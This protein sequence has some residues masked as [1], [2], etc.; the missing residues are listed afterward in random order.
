MSDYYDLLGIDPGADKDTIKS[1]Y[2]ERLEDAS[3]SERAKLNKAWN[4]LSDPVQRER[5]D[6]ARAEGWLDDAEEEIEVVDAAPRG[7]RGSRGGGGGGRE[8]QPRPPARPRPE[9]T[10]ELPEGMVLAENRE[11][12]NALLIDFLILFVVFTLGQFGIQA[13]VKAQYPAQSDRIDAIQKQVDKL[14]KQK[15]AQDKVA[16]GEKTKLTENQTPTKAQKAA[17]KTES[18][19]LDKRI[20]KLQDQQTEISKDYL[21]FTYL[22]LGG[23]V[24]VLLAIVVPITAITG[25]TIGQKIKK[26]RIVRQDGSPCGWGPAILRFAPP[27]LIAIVIPTLGALIGLGMV[28]WFLR[29]PNRQGFH[30]KLAKTIVVAAD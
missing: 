17:A 3:Q 26:V 29:D 12:G 5:Y 15:S 24:I 20:T 27:I 22:L 11:R 28:L 10:I 14:D 13:A 23:L 16:D 6:G 2:R 30:D 25:Q 9:P 18:K 19:A 8:R 1:A 4:V 7:A 21:G